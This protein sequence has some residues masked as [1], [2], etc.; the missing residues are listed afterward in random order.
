MLLKYLK[1]YTIMTLGL[2]VFVCG[3]VAFLN[4][5][6]ITGGG[7][8]GLASVIHY[9]INSIPVSYA[10]F[11][12]D[13]LL[14]V[15]GFIILGKGFGIKTIYC[16]AMSFVF[17]QFMPMIPGLTSISAGITDN[18]INALIG[19]AMSGI[20]IAIIITQ[21]GS[22]GGTDIIALS[23]NKY[24]NISPGRI[25]LVCD[26]LI[27]MS[28]LLVND[29]TLADVVYGFV[30]I[31]AFSYAVDMFLTGS[32]QS[33]QT[34]ILSE[35]NDEIAA[36]LQTLSIEG[37]RPVKS[38]QWSTEGDKKMLMVVSRKGY[39]NDIVKTAKQ[40][41]PDVILMTVP[42]TAVYGIEGK[43]Q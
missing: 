17:F 3:W 28:I 18:L 24:K 19:G 7:I 43:N 5:H 37:N 22:T 26:S 16:V 41:D 11:A 23:I 14:L 42:V 35:H 20:G 32:Q 38:V 6:E 31:I 13:I 29:K 30:E 39:S 21:G 9:G 36:R 40:I 27:V 34:L 15:A 10:K 33:V 8:A 2:A 4:P 25:Y 1:E 12:I